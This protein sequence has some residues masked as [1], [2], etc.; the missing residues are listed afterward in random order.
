MKLE[1]FEVFTA[2]GRANKHEEKANVLMQNDSLALRTLLRQLNM[3]R[4]LMVVQLC[5]K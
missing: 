2:L 3:K 5:M 4:E 1:I